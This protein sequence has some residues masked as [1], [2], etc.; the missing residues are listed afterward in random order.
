MPGLFGRASATIMCA[1]VAIDATRIPDAAETAQAP[2]A[3]PLRFHQLSI[4]TSRDA[5]QTCSHFSEALDPRAERA[6]VISA[7]LG[8][9][10]APITK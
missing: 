1:I 9:A 7:S 10:M 3:A 8:S 4:D 2:A 5:P 6:A